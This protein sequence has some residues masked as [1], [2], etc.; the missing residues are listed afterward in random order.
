MS[1][2]WWDPIS[3]VADWVGSKLSDVGSA[4][5]DYGGQALGALQ[6]LAG[7]A[8][9]Q[10][11]GLADT[12]SNALSG[13]YAMPVN[14]TSLAGID[15]ASSGAGADY[16]GLTGGAGIAASGGA[17]LMGKATDWAKKN[18]SLID[19]G[20]QAGLTLGRKTSPS[21]ATTAGYNAASAGNAARSA[22]GTS[23]VNQA[24]FLANNAE[25]AAKG[26]SASAESAKAQQLQQQGYKPG[27]AIYDSAMQQQKMDNRKAETTAYAAGQGQR[28]TQEATGAG[29]MTPNL[30]GYGAMA[31]EQN[32][33]QGAE[34]KQASDLAGLGKTAFD[35]WSNPDK[36][37]DSTIYN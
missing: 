21:A 2:N 1:N 11:A 26:A 36:K 25:A 22:V 9:T 24:P 20:I 35:I 33:Q 14:T 8:P 15:A 31:G 18:P 5:S 32:A 10:A 6:D 19:Q 37:T 23:L 27:D 29:L 4:V 13:G 30:T 17:D 34:N 3:D 12:S 16:S 7:S 28:A